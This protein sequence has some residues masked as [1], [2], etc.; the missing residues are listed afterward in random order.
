MNIQ[1]IIAKSIL[2]KSNIPNVDL[3]VNPYIGCEHGCIYCYAEFMKRFTAHHEPWGE[4]LDA[5]INSPEL[6][7][8]RGHYT[9]KI[10]MFS[11]VTDPYIPHERKYELTRK[12]LYRLI[13]YQPSITILT[14]SELFMRDIELFKQFKNIEV[15]I[16][17]ST[18]NDQYMKQLE[19]RA[20]IPLRRFNAI[21]KCHDAGLKTY[22]FLSPIFPFIT[23][24]EEIMEKTVDYVDYFMFENL[25]VRPH[26]RKR[27]FNF[28]KK[29]KPNLL[30]KYKEIF[31]KPQDHSYWD[32]LSGKIYNFGKKFNVECINCFHH[33][34]FTK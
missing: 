13:P 3:V 8:P 15:G 12:I 30:S 4:F 14:K 11:S 24:I 33:G 9:N 22:I 34:G 7:K 5:K 31:D 19:P 26:N 21:K 20:S 16:S 27:I 17:I 2:T 6:V 28:I 10:V 32:M 23:E 29:N 1:E 18:L 25:N